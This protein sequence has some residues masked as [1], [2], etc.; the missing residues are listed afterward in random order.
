MPF[1][2]N[3]S[4]T[5][6]PGNIGNIRP[7][8]WDSRGGLQKIEKRSSNAACRGSPLAQSRSKTHPAMDGKVLDL[9]AVEG[10][11]VWPSHRLLHGYA[12]SG[13]N[14]PLAQTISCDGPRANK[15]SARIWS[16]NTT[17]AKI[18]TQT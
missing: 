16:S 18:K 8:E 14:R 5:V 2:R 6:A 9:F 3:A 11:R 15:P 7:L 12:T 4:S 13:R 17:R 1:S 10:R